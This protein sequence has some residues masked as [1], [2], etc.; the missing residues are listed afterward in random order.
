MICDK[1]GNNVEFTLVQDLNS[2]LYLLEVQCDTCEKASYGWGISPEQALKRAK[3][4]WNNGVRCK[5]RHR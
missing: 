3:S 5:R 2:K 4:I 1:C